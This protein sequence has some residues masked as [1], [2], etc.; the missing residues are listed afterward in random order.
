MVHYVSQ[1][2]SSM[3]GCLDAGDVI[4]LIAIFVALC[5]GLMGIFQKQL[6]AWLLGDQL[7]LKGSDKEPFFQSVS[8]SPQRY[9]V[10]LLIRNTGGV[11]AEDVRAVLATLEEK[12]DWENTLQNR[13]CI[14]AKIQ[15]K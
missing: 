2:L 14:L 4:S 6:R 9:I 13:K 10:R 15:T 8:K 1:I 3:L 5:L 7:D 11:L 12:K